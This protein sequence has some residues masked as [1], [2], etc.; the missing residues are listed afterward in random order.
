ML[1]LAQDSA[2]A[3]ATDMPSALLVRAKIDGAAGGKVICGRFRLDFPPGAF[4]GTA[5]IQMA[6]PDSTLML[7]D[8]SI[9]PDS[10][11]AF[12]K[13]V[14]LTLDAGKLAVS[15]GSL[16]IYWYDPLTGRWVDMRSTRNLLTGEVSQQ[17]THFSRYLGGKAGW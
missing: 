3:V 7:C 10:L 17:L 6:A 8:L 15:T 13:P 1:A 16:S 5:T 14:V 11:N 9:A 12:S 4:A 2:L